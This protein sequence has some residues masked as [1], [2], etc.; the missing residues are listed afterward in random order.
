MHNLIVAVAEIRT[1]HRGSLMGLDDNGAG[2]HTDACFHQLDV[3]VSPKAQ[4]RI[5]MDMHVND[6][7]HK[8]LVHFSSPFSRYILPLSQFDEFS[9]ISNCLSVIFILYYS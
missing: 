4:V 8:I 7:F 9:S 2:A 3:I 6:T 1:I 5:G